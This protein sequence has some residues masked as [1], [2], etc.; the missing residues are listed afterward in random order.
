MF[1][2]IA[3]LALF[4]S[5]PTVAPVTGSCFGPCYI[6]GCPSITFYICHE[7]SGKTTVYSEGG[8]A[9]ST[10]TWDND[11]TQQTSVLGGQVEPEPGKTWGTVAA[12][13]DIL[14]WC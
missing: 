11:S 13:S 3:A 5:M 9:K 14:G 2:S 12:C 4:S 1:L 8:G 6:P 7:T 10:S